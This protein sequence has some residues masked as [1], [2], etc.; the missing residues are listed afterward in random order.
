MPA[1]T[2]PSALAGLPVPGIPS[3]RLAAVADRLL[4]GSLPR[5]LRQLQRVRACQHPV[6][7]SGQVDRV[8]P[9]TG[10]L[11]RDFDSH[12]AP[13]GVVLVPCGNRRSSRFPSCSD[14]YAGDA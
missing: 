8:D 10:E 4:D 9:V 5:F 12:D 7:L 2:L 11:T 3:V 1:A 13:D 14:L 6:R